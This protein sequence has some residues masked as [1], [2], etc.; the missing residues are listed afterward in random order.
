MIFK[1]FTFF[2]Q[3]DQMDCG[4]SCLRMIAKYYG[5]EY[6]LNFLKKNSFITREGVSLLGIS[7]AA[8]RIGLSTISGKLTL[9]ELHEKND[10]P[11]ILHWEQKH[12]V[13]LF[14]I[15]KKRFS[16]D[17]IY[18]IADPAH[19]IVKLNQKRF[20]NAWIGNVEKGIAMFVSKTEKFDE[21]KEVQ[22][23][24]VNF[25]FLLNLLKPYK[26]ELGKLLIGMAVASL[27]TLVFPFLTQLLIDKGV[28]SKNIHIVYIILIAQV[29]LFI[30]SI[31]LEIVRNWVLLY[32]GTRINISIISEFLIKI[33]KLPI[34]FFDSKQMGDFNQRINDHERVEYFLTSQSLITLF[35]TINFIVFF[36]VLLKYNVTILVSYTILTAI[37][38]S[39]SM[40]FLKKRKNLDYYKFQGRSE[41]Q[42]KIYELINGIQEIKL[43]GFEKYKRNSWEKIQLKIFKIN[44]K[45]LKVEQLQL[46]GF[47]FINQLKNILVTFL[48]AKEV[49]DGSITLGTMLAI[50]YIIGQLNSPVNQIVS[51]FRSFQDAK[52]SLERLTEI[53][54]EKNE[55]KQHHVQFSDS[56]TAEIKERGIKLSEVDFQFEGPNSQ[57]ILKDI[58]LL[59][60]EGKTTAIVGESGSGKTTL[61]KLLLNFYEP[62]KG[63]IEIHDQ[64]ILDLSPDSWRKNCGVVMQEGYLFSETIE[65]NIVMGDETI[66]Q[67]RLKNAIRTANIKKYIDT[68]PLQ[69]NTKIGSE[70]N[71]LSGGQKQRI[72]IARAVYKNPKFLFFDEATSAL[73]SEN[74]KIIHDNLQTFFKGKT[75]MIIA[76]RLSTVKNADQII[77]LKNGKIEEK[78]T[79]DE[80]VAKKKTYFNLIKNQLE[81]S[82]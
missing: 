32:L 52:L 42:E 17:Y 81:L 78:G 64:N 20:L 28:A 35:S 37:A 51:F 55:Q 70:G 8:K 65:R 80:L 61:M 29:F 15:K 36:F 77:V 47:E 66:D 54:N 33:F 25:H 48:A 16:N 7:E 56:K 4:P 30:G 49:I 79:H 3:H 13:V 45:I 26:K 31:T 19:G 63:K 72:L 59:I 46:M 76:H 14:K 75:V 6:S 57:Y 39:W 53:Q 40:V 23:E 71:G 11:S 67:V 12:F 1:S 34:H 62:T 73:D 18:Y 5:K 41:N 43:N 21:L 38:I 24:K 44:L 2:S 60:E 9:A 27:I 58:N 50:S 74:E 22:N 69:L 82:V 68:L 10:F